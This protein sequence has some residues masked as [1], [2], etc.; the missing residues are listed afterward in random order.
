MSNRDTTFNIGSGTLSGNN[1]VVRTQSGWG[2]RLTE[3]R[4]DKETIA[5]NTNPRNSYQQQSQSQSNPQIQVQ[6]TQSQSIQP[7]QLPQMQSQQVH[8][9]HNQ[10]YYKHQTSR[11]ILNTVEIDVSVLLRIIKHCME[12]YQTMNAS[13]Q[14]LGME[15][16]N[17]LEITTSFQLPTREDLL[18][19]LASHY[20]SSKVDKY[21]KIDIEERIL[22]E[23]DKYQTSMVELMHEMRSDCLVL[24]WYQIIRLDDFQDPGIV[25]TL[26][27]YHSNAEC[28]SAV[29]LGIDSELLIQGKQNAFKAYTLGNEYLS[30]IKEYDDN[31][32]II[33]GVEFEDILI[34][35]PIYIKY[36]VL[37]EAF[38]LD[39]ATFDILQSTIDFI[40]LPSSHR[41]NL[42]FSDKSLLNLADSIDIL[43]IEQE[44][45]IKN[46]RD[47][48]KQQYLVK[49][50]AERKR[51]ENEQRKLKGENP[52]PIDTESIKKIEPPNPLP[53][54]L[55]SKY[56]DTQCR[57]INSNAIEGLSKLLIRNIPSN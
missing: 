9:Q 20:H 35:I 54:I 40:E 49:Q 42:E 45:F 51:I 8:N 17:K 56:V 5:V 29:F 26:L 39:W 4:E 50:M 23:I 14:L 13:G 24:G 43:S 31:Y 55:M 47:Y 52:L 18:S 53:V 7:P 21:D 15:Y 28:K 46:H 6:I 32:S 34:E 11:T 33:K 12:S 19:S 25:S 44:R 3:E 38:L 37:S 16:G 27:S 57:D 48:M 22:E 2:N 10:S 41:N 36:P 30:R 1:Q